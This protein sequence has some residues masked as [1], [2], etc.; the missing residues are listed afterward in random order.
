MDN[1]LQNDDSLTESK[2]LSLNFKTKNYGKIVIL[3]LVLIIA[4][5]W[6]I[7]KSSNS[8]IITIISKD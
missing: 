5:F 4:V 8:G 1:N 3:L 6:F 2:D 7:Y